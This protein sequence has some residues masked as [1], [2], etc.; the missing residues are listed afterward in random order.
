M[1]LADRSLKS[2]KPLRHCLTFAQPFYS[3]RQLSKG[4]HYIAWPG[5]GFRP[6]GPVPFGGEPY[7][8]LVPFEGGLFRRSCIWLGEGLDRPP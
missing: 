3:R 8:D 4:G 5:T 7:G 6:T 1:P 2:S